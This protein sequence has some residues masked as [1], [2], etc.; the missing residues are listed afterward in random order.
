MGVIRRA[1]G[2]SLSTNFERQIDFPAGG[3]LGEYQFW[4]EKKTSG[5]HHPAS[6]TAWGIIGSRIDSECL[7]V[8]GIVSLSTSSPAAFRMGNKNE[9]TCTSG[10]T[11]R[12]RGRDG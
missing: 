5:K 12:R 1:G 9:T 2:G 3:G 4:V 7:G 8:K 6:I 11:G 10:A